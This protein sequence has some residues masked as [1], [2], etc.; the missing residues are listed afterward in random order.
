MD[1][2]CR[3]VSPFS[4]GKTEILASFYA[5]HHRV[6]KD[7]DRLSMALQQLLTALACNSILTKPPVGAGNGIQ[8]QDNGP[9]VPW[10]HSKPLAPNTHFI[11][12]IIG[13]HRSN[14]ASWLGP[15]TTLVMM[16]VERLQLSHCVNRLRRLS[17]TKDSSLEYWRD[18]KPVRL[19]QK[20][21]RLRAEEQYELPLAST[22]GLER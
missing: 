14:E 4:Q 21:E 12:L 16:A 15:V 8:N 1:V 9:I 18:T 13:T 17:W 6:L 2:Y 3:Q 19:T 11:I 5:K 7:I 22:S 20:I 10:V